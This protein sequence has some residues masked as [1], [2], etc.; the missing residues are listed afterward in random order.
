MIGILISALKIIFLLGFLIAIH[1]TGHFIVAKKCKVRVNE[2]AIGFGPTI[3]KKQGAETKYAIRLIPLGGYVSMEG[4]GEHSDKEGSFTKAPVGKR[5]GIVA[6]GAIVNIL[7]ALI[8]Y[9]ILAATITNNATTTIS[10]VIPGYSAEAAGIQQGDKIKKINNRKVKSASDIIEKVSESNGD[11]IILIVERDNIEKELTIT[12]TK[13]ENSYYLGIK[14]QV[15]ENNFKNHIYYATI[16]TGSFISSVLES[17]KQLFTAKIS[18]D[19][20]M[21]PVGISE[22]VSKTSGI[23]EFIY[24]L[25]LISMSLGVTN[26]IP[27]PP[28]DGG[29]ILLLVIEAIT[30]KP[31]K[32]EVEI[33]IEMIGFA[34]LI[35]LS[36]YVTYHD[37]LRII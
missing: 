28:L 12:P 26:L 30:K 11:E 7:F 4:E 19:Q 23:R 17:L 34:I 24:M 16:N 27:F 5:I 33:Q 37:I 9:F 29:K 2:F 10:E 36:I 21:G 25:A 18:I 15:A 31:M 13:I 35:A 32:E 20:M 14:F 22:V 8:V 6:A 1:E 3:W